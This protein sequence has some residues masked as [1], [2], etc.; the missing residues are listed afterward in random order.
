[1]QQEVFERQYTIHTRKDAIYI[2][3]YIHIIS[4]KEIKKL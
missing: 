2:Y 1:L 3:I 4:I